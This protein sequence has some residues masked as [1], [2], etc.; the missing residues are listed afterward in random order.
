MMRGESHSAIDAL[1]RAEEIAKDHRA[2]V[3]GRALRLAHLAEAHLM[4]GNHDLAYEFADQAT[5]VAEAQGGPVA[6]MPASLA[7]AR[8]LLAAP[9]PLQAERIE[10]ELT[11]VLDLVVEIGAR[12]YEP[13]VRVEIARL[14]S[15]LGEDA[16]AE[17]ELEQARRLF[18]ENGA[19]AQV[20]ELDAEH[21]GVAEAR[22]P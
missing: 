21:G 3:D 14:A 19:S 16:R 2:A 5:V 8:V 9:G 18:T 6:I 10:A 4:A 1:E 12:G 20:A 15:R 17:R 7:I 13:M 11:A 22:Q